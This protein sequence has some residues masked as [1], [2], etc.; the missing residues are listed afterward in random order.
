M[1][2]FT[3][4]DELLFANEAQQNTQSQADNSSSLSPWKIMI[5]DDDDVIHDV[6]HLVLSD[7]SF[8][9]RPIQIIDGYS[10]QEAKQLIQ[11]HPDTALILLDVVME[12]DHAGLDVVKFIRET[13]HNKEVRIILR[14]GQPGSAPEEDIIQNYD[15][16]DY[17]E[18]TELTARKLHSTV[19]TSLRS[20]SRL[21]SENEKSLQPENREMLHR[22]ELLEKQN[23]QLREE[24]EVRKKIN[25]ELI[26]SELSLQ[27]AQQ[28]AKIGHWEWLP[29]NDKQFYISEQARHLI[30]ITENI[31]KTHFDNLL[32]YFSD[33]DKQRF[34]NT[35]KQAL[36]DKSSFKLDLQLKSQ[37][38]KPE[39]LHL[40]GHCFRNSSDEIVRF[41]ITL[42]AYASTK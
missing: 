34:K 36:E 22:I 2:N 6:S 39:R 31:S 37:A 32:N 35:F 18:K 14:T 25:D 26:R 38:D 5:I 1:L 7:I 33:D 23:K 30:G 12:T 19:I 29:D 10:A 3:E 8:A 21:I 16:N 40:G 11:E 9:S 42:Q 4:N 17:K 20:Y 24:L 41:I 13:I 27:L 15:I 28:V